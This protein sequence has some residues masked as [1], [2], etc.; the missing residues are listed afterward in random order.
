MLSA[1]VSL[2]PQKTTRAS[3][4]INESLQSLAQQGVNYQVGPISTEIHG[5]EE[6][7][8]SGIRSLFNKASSAGEVNMVVTF[9]NS[10]HKDQK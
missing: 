5:S 7:V 10:A 2:Y 6:Q 9:S 1:E 3:E 4:I 8:W